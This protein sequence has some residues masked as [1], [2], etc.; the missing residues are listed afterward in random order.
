MADYSA[1]AAKIGQICPMLKTTSELM[2]E[3]GRRREFEGRHGFVADSLSD[4]WRACRA[5]ASG[6]AGRPGQRTRLTFLT[7]DAPAW[8]AEPLSTARFCGFSSYI[9]AV[10]EAPELGLY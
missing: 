8:I 6:Q 3:L 5:P 1:S 10:R 9:F 4:A 2:E 7:S